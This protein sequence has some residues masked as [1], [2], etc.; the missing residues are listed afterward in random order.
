MNT[1]IL[2]TACLIVIVN[3][4]YFYLGKNVLIEQVKEEYLF[5]LVLTLLL[6]VFIYMSSKLKKIGIDKIVISN[7]IS[8][9]STIIFFILFEIYDYYSFDGLEGMIKQW[10]F[11]WILGAI[12]LLLMYCIQ[13][14]KVLK[15]HEIP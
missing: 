1:K 15:Y 13:A 10:L 5:I 3:V 6:G 8:F 12:S 4:Y 11:Y 14:Y 2:Y 9:K 7:Q